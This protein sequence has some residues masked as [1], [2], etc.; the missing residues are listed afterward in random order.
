MITLDG[1]EHP[2]E[3]GQTLLAAARGAG[4]YVPKL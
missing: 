2:L 4:I 1:Q 3:P